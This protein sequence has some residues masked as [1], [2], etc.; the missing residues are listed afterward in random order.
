MKRNPTHCLAAILAAATFCATHLPA[1]DATPAATPDPAA[2]PAA[3]EVAKVNLKFTAQAGATIVMRRTIVQ[4]IDQIIEGNPAHTRTEQLVDLLIEVHSIEPNGVVTMKGT[5]RRLRQLERGQ[6]ANMDYDSDRGDPGKDIAPV[7]LN[8][9][10]GQMFW[11]QVSPDGRI[12]NIKGATEIAQAGF[13]AADLPENGML[14][15]LGMNLVNQWNDAAMVRVLSGYFSNLPPGP[16]APG[17]KW[18]REGDEMQMGVPVKAKSDYTL[19]S[20]DPA[21]TVITGATSFTGVP[22]PNGA[23]LSGTRTSTLEINTAFGFLA[24]GTINSKVEGSLRTP[25]G[26]LPTKADISVVIETL[27][28]G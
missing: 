13:V 25:M 17:E 14:F 1:Q 3:G 6:F 28:P 9:M 11:F 4:E 20:S 26:L 18:S 16:V 24:K 10:K 21:T 7:F 22:Q 12:A 27:P 2:A 19:L 8:A 15:D 23:T 5:F